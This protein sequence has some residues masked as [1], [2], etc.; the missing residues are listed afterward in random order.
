MPLKYFGPTQEFRKHDE[1]LDRNISMEDFD[2]A[3]GTLKNN[4]AP[5][6]DKIPNEFLKNCHPNL[7]AEI[8]VLF[9]SIWKTEQTPKKWSEIEMT[10]LFKKGDEQLPVNYRGIELINTISKLF[11]TI[12]QTRL[13]NWCEKHQILPESLPTKK[14]MPR[15][16]FLPQL[17]SSSSTFKT[18]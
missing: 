2:S 5:G 10:T 17:Y 13:Y 12:I 16:N 4:K 7:K 8:L 3:L 15:P 6:T 11:T 9:N 14:R 1:E 18:S